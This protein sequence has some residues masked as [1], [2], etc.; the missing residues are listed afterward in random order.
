MPPVKHRCFVSRHHADD[1]ELNT[2]V[3]KFADVF[4]ARVLGVTDDDPFIGSSNNNY[5]MSQ[6]RE[7]YLTGTMVTIVLVG[8]CTWARRYVDWE[9]AS[10]IRD[11]PKNTRS[12][13]LAIQLPSAAKMSPKP[14][15]PPRLAAN[16][17]SDKGYARYWTYPRTDADLRSMIEDAIWRRDNVKPVSGDPLMVNSRSCP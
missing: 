14:K 6:I 15:L 16:Y 1:V 2:F 3:A 7:K 10:T 5:V 4:T 9:I 11:D 12:G 17:N 13:L 8:A